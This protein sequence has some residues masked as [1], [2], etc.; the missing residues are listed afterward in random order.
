[1][2]HKLVYICSPLRGNIEFNQE[3]CREYCRFACNLGMI[4]FAPHIFYTQFLRDDI[5]SE[6]NIGIECGLE[7]L[8]RCDELWAFVTDENDITEGMIQE[9]E[10]A[11]DNDILVHYF[12]PNDKAIIWKKGLDNE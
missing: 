11:E 2:N 3:K 1:M 12:Y 6:R 9:I 8:K 7:V 10:F 4:P 5:E